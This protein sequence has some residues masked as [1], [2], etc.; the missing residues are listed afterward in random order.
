[1]ASNGIFPGTDACKAER[2]KTKTFRRAEIRAPRGM[3]PVLRMTRRFREKKKGKKRFGEKNQSRMERRGRRLKRKVP[4][5][6]FSFTIGRTTRHVLR[7][8]RHKEGGAS[9]GKEIKK[10]TK[11][12][13]VPTFPCR[14]KRKC[15]SE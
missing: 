2:G 9:T 10:K 5:R 7:E 15:S 14:L 6:S 4:D 3:C 13:K 1:L 11:K 12:V 8:I